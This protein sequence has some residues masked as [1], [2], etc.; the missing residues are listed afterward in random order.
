M[1]W[2]WPCEHRHTVELLV[3]KPKGLEQVSHI[4]NVTGCLPVG[5][6]ACVVALFHAK[7]TSGDVLT[8]D[9]FVG[10]AIVALAASRAKAV[11]E[12]FIT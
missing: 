8:P 2:R 7:R 1:R 10:A 5:L 9:E 4:P 12:N 6:I 11:I 3:Q